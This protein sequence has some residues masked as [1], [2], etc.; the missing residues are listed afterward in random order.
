[1]HDDLI[2]PVNALSHNIDLET[3]LAEPVVT[4]RRGHHKRYP[5]ARA[6]GL[7]AVD[8]YRPVGVHSRNLRSHL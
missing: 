2:F 7:H 6:T 4:A 8:I 5:P 3:L 1:M